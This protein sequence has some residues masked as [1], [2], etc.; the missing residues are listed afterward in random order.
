MEIVIIILIILL[1]LIL[2]AA[3]YYIRKMIL[4]AE[5]Y[6]EISIAI[7]KENVELW[8]FF[9]RLRDEIRGIHLE[10]RSIDNRGIFEKDDHGGFVFSKLL[11]LSEEIYDYVTARSDELEK[12]KQKD[13]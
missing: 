11:E 12:G 10:M 4:L 9:I 1:I 6:Q 8:Q 7:D 13:N 2:V 3:V 5:R